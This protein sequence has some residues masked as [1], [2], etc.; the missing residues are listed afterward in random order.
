MPL[1]HSRLRLIMRIFLA[2]LLTLSA[3][4]A[5]VVWLLQRNPQALADH[6]IEQLAAR[7]GLT[8][9][10]ESVNVALLPLPSLAVSNAS[11]DGQGWKFTAAYAT[12]RPDFLA[13][14]RGELRPR[15]IT[16]LRPHLTGS[17]PVALPQSLAAAGAD[18]AAAP[19]IAPP[20]PTSPPKNNTI[21]DQLLA[22]VSD[23]DGALIPG[24]FRLAVAQGELNVAGTDGARLLASGLECDVEA[25]A[26]TR[27]KG[28]LS[29]SA[30]ELQPQG[31]PASR[32][33][34]LSVEGKTDV[35]A[36][37]LRTPK[38]SAKGTLRLPDWLA[39]LNFAV[40]LQADEHGWMLGGDLEGDLREDEVLLPAHLTGSVAMHNRADN[41]ISLE[42][43]RLRLGPDDVGLNGMLRL[44]GPD[45]FTI[46]GRLQLHR[47][48]LT[49]WLGFARNLAPG[50]QVALDELTEGTLDFSMDGNG[51][52]VPHI[53]VTAAGSRFVGSGGVASWSH[54]E[55]ALDLKAEVVNLGRAIP[56]SV[57][58]LPAE[59]QYGHD[60]LTPLPGRPVEPGEVGVDY[61]IRLGADRVDYGP[62]VL[63]N[64]LVVIK[65]GMVDP[66]TH[67]EDTLLLVDGA[68]YGGSVKG[69]TILGG[70]PDTPYAIRLHLRDVN[71][72]ALAHD[73]PVMPVSGGKLRCD[74]D[75]MSQGKELDE[76]LSKLRG[77]VTARGERGRLRPPSNAGGKSGAVSTPFKTLDVA[78]KARTAAWD[79]G[80]L[81]LEGQWSA[82]IADDGMNADLDL[83]GR[84]WFSG[85]GK[86]GGNM[87]FQA[88][89]GTLG[90]T[91]STE[92]S[93]PPQGLQAQV[94]GKFSCQAARNQLSASEAHIRALGAE[95][96]GSAQLGLGKDGLSW[97]GKAAAFIPDVEHTLRL[98]GAV[99]P[100]L[101]QSLR[102][103]ELDATFKGDPNSLS[104][105]AFHASVDKNDISG[106]LGVDW[107]K[108][109]A[110]RFKL[111]VPQLDLDRYMGPKSASGKT[112][113]PQPK[114]AEESKAWDLRFMR[115]FNAE[116]QVQVGQ[117]TLWRLHTQNLH[118]KA[119][120]D[121]G[122][123]RF[124]SLGAK[125]YGAPLSTHG[126]LRFNKGLTFNNALSVDGFDL[127]AASRDRGGSAALGGRGSVSSEV[128][129]ELTGSRQLPARL[130]GKW[131]VSVADGFYQ[132]RDKEGRLKGKPTRFES[133][134]SSG[135]LTNGIAKS[136]DFYLKGQ[137]LKVNGG[138]WV[139]LNNETLDCNFTVNMKNLPDFPM[140]LYGSLDNSK[141]SIG[142]GKL[143][144]NTIG[145]ITQG[146]VDVLGSVVE[147]TWKLFR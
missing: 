33:E 75:I 29:C 98:L 114:K 145:G 136:G 46:D 8:I 123:L 62:I 32:L 65:Q 57:G 41:L 26:M 50:L 85:D 37:L 45:K 52:R 36:P 47:A 97:Q 56:E 49:E 12:L 132:S 89:P 119:R 22:A 48:S 69:D 54:P 146:V 131:R 130:N 9:R 15:N 3:L 142:A 106:S 76:F 27:L 78:L 111:T 126:E 91:L 120:L 72:D 113:K 94:S 23:G 84:I 51:L 125:F 6:Y 102:R 116:G 19:A 28:R 121:N 107:R 38:L 31:Q 141:T 147:G 109:L 35:S 143:L 128:G 34:H 118:L 122:V 124:E 103:V 104:L 13:L 1:N 92:K 133:A 99:P 144:L 127:S 11:V 53:E 4:A 30:L 93:F 88:L 77:T 139:N 95:I 115:A 40:N 10:V 108:E 44:G 42:N 90:I 16:L 73:L 25:T 135:V 58:V 66:V 5:G 117:L 86:G 79:Q 55:V 112:E 60:P 18:T 80:R 137:D 17:L 140:R 129:A 21:L 43:L 81:G 83:N 71:G 96:T 82:T 61:N 105:S 110:L 14:L 64:A 59:P 138:G 2:L 68:L 134:G 20:A 24:R 87:D 63:N 100:S 7:T 101:P 70:S 39:R 67:L 74:V